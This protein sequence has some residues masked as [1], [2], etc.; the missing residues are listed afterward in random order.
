[1]LEAML[2]QVLR[3]D[4]GRVVVGRHVVYR[5]ASFRHQLS[6]VKEAQSGFFRLGTEGA[7]S[8][9]V[10]RRRVVAVQRHLRKLLAKPFIAKA[11]ATRSVSMVDMAVRLCRFDLKLTG[12]FDSII[13]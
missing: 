12:A 7:V 3:A 4:V 8:Q 11:D 10:H 5:K 6:D 2:V 1:M 9:R 13:R